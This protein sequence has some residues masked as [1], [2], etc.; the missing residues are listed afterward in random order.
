MAY[1]NR[2][3]NKTNGNTARCTV[4]AGDGSVAF[5]PS[6]NLGNIKETSSKDFTVSY[7]AEANSLGEPMKIA[8]FGGFGTFDKSTVSQD[9]KFVGLCNKSN[10][11]R[12]NDES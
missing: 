9:G 1:N 4:S 3:S 10:T 11:S 12:N 5:S 6:F 2:R 8:S 7:D